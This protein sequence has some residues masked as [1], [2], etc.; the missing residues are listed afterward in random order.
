MTVT[1]YNYIQSELMKKGLNEMVNAQGELIFFK[2]ESQFMT[3]ILAYDEDVSTIIDKIF[4]GVSLTQYAHD[5]HFKKTFMY[6]FL[7]RRINGQTIEN[8]RVK[9]LTTFLMNQDYINRVYTDLELYLAQTGSSDQQSQS[10][11]N[12]SNSQTNKTSNRQTNSQTNTQQTDGSSTGDN[13]E[14]DARL[15]Q[16]NVQL[17]VNSTVMTAADSNRISRNKQL[18]NQLVEGETTGETI[19]IN[20]TEATAESTS[21]N[22]STSFSENKSYRLDELFK[23]QG[24]QERIFNVFDGKCFMQIW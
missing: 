24:I 19:G 11:T 10:A 22:D 9:L 5:I 20:D 16:N 4:T 17:D 23:T 8:F 12:D 13:R 6:H 14:A 18:D 15:P 3:K 2:E 21:E 1:L 7:N